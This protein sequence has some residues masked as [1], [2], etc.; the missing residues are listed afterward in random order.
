MRNQ[1]LCIA[2][3][4]AFVTVGCVEEPAPVTAPAPEEA[5]EAAA[6]PETDLSQYALEVDPVCG[7][8]LKEHAVA[9]TQEHEGKTYGFCSEY[10]RDTFAKDPAA[11]LAK[12][13]SGEAGAMPGN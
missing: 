11:A 10:C 4:F 7:M 6:T 5:A 8:S 9:A 2:A 13:G 3:L 1:W 12:A